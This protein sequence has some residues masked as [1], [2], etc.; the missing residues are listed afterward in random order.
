MYEYSKYSPECAD[1]AYS[2]FPLGSITD[3]VNNLFTR[4]TNTKYYIKIV[5]FSSSHLNI[6]FNN[7]VL[8]SNL[9]SFD[10]VLIDDEY[11]IEIISTTSETIDDLELNYQVILEETFSS[12]CTAKI[13]ILECYKSCELC[14]KTNIDSDEEN[15]N[16]VAGKCNINYYQ[17]PDIETNCWDIYEAQPNWYLDY[18]QNK[19][20]YCNEECPTCD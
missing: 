18:E 5:S 11:N 19:F 4:K 7:E 16:C 2:L 12:N 10:P 8:E 15:H 3:D 14:T 17:D 9:T 13:N 1:K 6:K 20:F